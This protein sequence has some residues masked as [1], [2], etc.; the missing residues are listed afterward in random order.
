MGIEEEEVL[1]KDIENIVNN[2]I[3][4]NLPSFEKERGHPGFQDAP[5]ARS[6]KKHL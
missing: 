1:A 2:I 4:R 3:A 5:Q 6:E